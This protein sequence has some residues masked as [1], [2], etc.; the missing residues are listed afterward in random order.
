MTERLGFIGT[1]HLGGAIVSGLL[2]AGFEVTI[3]D[4]NPA[5]LAA[6]RARAQVEEDELVSDEIRAALLSFSK[7]PRVG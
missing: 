4:T 3:Y 5:P 6:L 7:P 1:G 2:K